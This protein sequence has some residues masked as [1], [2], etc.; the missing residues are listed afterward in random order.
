[1]KASSVSVRLRAASTVALFAF[2]SACSGTDGRSGIE[3]PLIVSQAQFV[4]GELPGIK[5]D[6]EEVDEDLPTTSPPAAES[7]LIRERMS[8]IDFSGFASLSATAIGVRF[9][10]EGSGYY[11]FPTGAVDAQDRTRLTWRFQADLQDALGSGL[12]ELTSVAFDEEG[13]PGKQSNMTLCVRSLRPDNG[14][15]CYA[16]VAPPALVV[17]VEWDTPVDL[18]LILVAPSGVVLNPKHPTTADADESGVIDPLTSGAGILLGDGNQDC[19][20]D[21]KQ[22]ED[23]VFRDRPDP[24]TYKVY[25]NLSRACG[26]HAVSYET[27]RHARVTE[28]E[29]YS[30]SSRILGAGSLLKGQANGGKAIGTFVAEFAVD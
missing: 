29:E 1:M 21:G 6:A 17:S 27:S 4:E 5:A 24:G 16:H 13:R 19:V 10:D 12:F 30:V 22:R 25:V 3:E 26:E 15:S 20:V 28:G 2:S 7:A 18:D 23:I 11:L 14:N 9:E 8:G